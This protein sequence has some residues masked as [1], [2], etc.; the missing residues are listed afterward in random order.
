MIKSPLA[1]VLFGF[2]LAGASIVARLQMNLPES[3]LPIGFTIPTILISYLV[4]G[5]WG[6]I[7]AFSLGVVALDYMTGDDPHSQAVM[8]GYLAI[9]AM[10][11]ITADLNYR[12][13]RARLRLQ[14]ERAADAET[15]AEEFKHRVK[16]LLTVVQALIAQS[17]GVDQATRDEITSRLGALANSQDLLDRTGSV[18]LHELVNASLKPFNDH[19]NIEVVGYD[20]KVPEQQSVWLVLALHELATNAAKYGALSR[21]T[22]RVRVEMN[23]TRN[24][25]SLAWR[26]FGGPTVSKPTVTGFGSRLLDRAKA[27]ID[28]RP[29]GIQCLIP[30]ITTVA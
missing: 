22:G 12:G 23:E 9:G 8:L 6:G 25:V 28:Y 21:P 4:A 18:N 5:R 27:E 13:E 11:I 20:C 19:S 30:R 26:E 2:A 14:E 7:A 24:G 3:V 1:G 16:N 17:L 15:V 29:D 10:I